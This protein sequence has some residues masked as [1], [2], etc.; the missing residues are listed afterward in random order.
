MWIFISLRITNVFLQS[1]R[2]LLLELYFTICKANRALSDQPAE[3]G[4]SAM[5]R[6]KCWQLIHSS[7]TWWGRGLGQIPLLEP[8]FLIL[9]CK[10]FFTLM[11]SNCVVEYFFLG[12]LGSY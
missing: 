8:S 10:N 3:N 7:L 6:D 5:L 4:D 2:S 12:G 11:L 1:S 9:A